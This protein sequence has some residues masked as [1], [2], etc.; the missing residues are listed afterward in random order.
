MVPNKIRTPQKHTQDLYFSP[1]YPNKLACAAGQFYGLA[2]LCSYHS[3]TT[4]KIMFSTHLGN[5]N[6]FVILKHLFNNI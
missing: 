6:V 2:G 1:F 4:D 5:W 3:T